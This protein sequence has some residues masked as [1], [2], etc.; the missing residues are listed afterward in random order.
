MGWFSRWRERRRE[1]A[2]GVDADLVED[3][4]KR[5]KRVSRLFAC[6]VV[7]FLIYSKGKL[8]RPVDQIIF[9]I[10]AVCFAAGILLAEWARAEDSFLNTPNRPDPP[11]IWK[12]RSRR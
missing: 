12:F 3:N 10:G 9:W 6:G 4:R 8:P 7:L 11:S 1:L 5:W 2:A